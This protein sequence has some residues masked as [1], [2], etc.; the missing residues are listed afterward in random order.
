MVRAL[1][2]NS[3]SI[4]FIDNPNE[5]KISAVILELAEPYIKMY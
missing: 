5:I 1:G 4:D 2:L 3:E